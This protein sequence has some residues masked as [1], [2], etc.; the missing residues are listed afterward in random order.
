MRIKISMGKRSFEKKE[1]L[2]M[3][4]L[5]KYS[6][7]HLYACLIITIILKSLSSSA[8]LEERTSISFVFLSYTF[9]NLLKPHI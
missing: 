4:L 9:L 3:R 2:V 7:I 6:L 8:D 5:T 1:R